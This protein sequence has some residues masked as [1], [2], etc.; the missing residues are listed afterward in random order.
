MGQAA[1]DVQTRWL[2]SL[3]ADTP[4]EQE[5]LKTLAQ[6]YVRGARIDWKEVERGHQRRLTDLP[7]YPW[8]RQRYWFPIASRPTAGQRGTERWKAMLACGN[9]QAGQIPI[10]LLLHTYADKYRALDQ[11]A[12][13]YIVRTL[14]KLGAFQSAGATLRASDLVESYGVLPLYRTLIE[15][16]LRKLADEGMLVEAA[17]TFTAAKPLCDLGPEAL[18]MAA[19]P[20]FADASMLLDYLKGCGRLLTAVLLGQASPLETLFPGGSLELAEA[21]YHRA[22][23]S[24]YFNGIAGAVAGA[25]AQQHHGLL[26]VLEVGAGTG[27]TTASILPMLPTDRTEY[28]FTDVS[29][30]FFSQAV[31]R[32]E[33][34]SHLKFGLLDL[35][36]APDSQGYN[37]GCFDMIVAAN[38]LHATKDLGQTLD[39]VRSLLAADGVL[40]LYEITN[41]PAY[42]DVSTALIEGWHK[43]ADAIRNSNPLLTTDGWKQ[44]LLE[45]GFQDVISWPATATPVEV[46]GSHVFAARVTS[47]AGVSPRQPAAT[48]AVSSA[49][50]YAA[51]AA[52]D[53]I[54][55]VLADA[56]ETEHAE[57][58]IG[59][60]RRHVT[61]VL[62]RSA[63]TDIPRDQRLMD[64][65]LDSLMAVELRNSL[66]QSLQLTQSLPAT[67][68]FDCPSI[69]DIAAYLFAQLRPERA[70]AL[71]GNGAKIE[72]VRQPSGEASQRMTAARLN[73][74]S[75]ADVE[76]LLIDKLE[77]T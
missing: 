1:C 24:R 62:R 44:C 67:L 31:R 43:S 52:T 76:S 57:M 29:E 47:G 59:L 22:A 4:P 74:L 10:D 8:Q 32:F 46:L 71:G 75:D 77:P 13:A 17:G 58:L 42:F 63:Q 60:V 9:R 38:V 3:T 6:L 30:F 28:T 70:S 53:D 23:Q 7:G 14:Q 51:E 15:R 54:L 35:E 50:A 40:L 21:I 18:E 49:R 19:V 11:L 27:G 65:G 61:R 68:M 34:Y 73:E 5:M 12:T 16:W 64:L 66:S 33:E 25:F 41:P 36:R 39:F 69:A 56:P 72:T 55:E 45:H 20:L 37:P 2:Q 26:R 48:S